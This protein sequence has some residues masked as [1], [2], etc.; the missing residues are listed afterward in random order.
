MQDSTGL[1]YEWLEDSVDN[2]GCTGS[3]CMQA[4]ADRL[5]HIGLDC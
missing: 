4:T 1:G 5:C 2:T 3:G